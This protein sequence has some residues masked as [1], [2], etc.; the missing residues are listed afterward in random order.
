MRHV[1]PCIIV[2]LLVCTM[3]HISCAADAVPKEAAVVTQSPAG[4]TE[5]KKLLD[6]GNRLYAASNY[7]QAIADYTEVERLLAGTNDPNLLNA[8]YNRGLAY[9]KTGYY[10]MAIDDFTRVLNLS[11]GDVPAY[12]NRGNAFALSKQRTNAIDDYTKAIALDPANGTLYFAR[13]ITL[14]EMPDTLDNGIEDFKKAVGLNPADKKSLCFLGIAYYKKKDYRISASYF[15]EAI[16]VDPR[17]K[18]AYTGRGQANLKREREAEAIADFKKACE[19]GER[20]GCTM[21]DLLARKD[22]GGLP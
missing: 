13:G 19:M 12:L 7:Q 5:I 14:Q 3:T 10:Q 4:A 16:R 15:D 11:P 6:E 21:S 17:F 22:R 1:L 8:M 20:L 2:V 9:H 18:E